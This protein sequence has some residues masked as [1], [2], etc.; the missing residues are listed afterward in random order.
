[1]VAFR[2]ALLAI[3]PSAGIYADR[4]VLSILGAL[5][6]ILFIVGS[7]LAVWRGSRPMRKASA[8]LAITAFVLNAHWYLLYVSDRP[9]LGIGYFLWW[10][11]F[12]WLAAGLF[13][14]SRDSTVRRVIHTEAQEPT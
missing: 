6:T 1:V 14:L 7:P 9:G 11:S 2:L 10:L 13:R 3:W 8:W 12:G 5:T 4:P